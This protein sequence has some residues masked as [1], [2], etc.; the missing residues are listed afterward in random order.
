VKGAFIAI[1]VLIG[2]ALFL[3]GF[4]YPVLK[5]DQ[6]ASLEDYERLTRDAGAR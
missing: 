3:G 1:G 2:V 4:V 5:A 6:D